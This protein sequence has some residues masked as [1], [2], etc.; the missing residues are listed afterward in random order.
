LTTF[1][2]TAAGTWQCSAALGV[3]VVAHIHD[4]S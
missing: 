3:E 4:G 2:S 1:G